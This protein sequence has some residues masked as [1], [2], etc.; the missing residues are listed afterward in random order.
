MAAK[1]KAQIEAETKLERAM[2]LL[3]NV[4]V[5]VETADQSGMVQ[6]AGAAREFLD[7]N[8]ER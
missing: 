1:T 8:G 6:T 4:T 7:T 5:A 3:R 2:E